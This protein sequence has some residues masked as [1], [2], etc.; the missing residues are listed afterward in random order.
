MGTA[1]A[2]YISEG[3]VLGAELVAVCDINKERLEWAR[4]HFEEGVQ[5]FEAVEDLLAFDGLDAVMICTLHYTHPDYAIKAFSH[6]LHVLIEKPAGVYT[7]QVREM[8]E[9]ARKSGLVFGIM[10]NQRTNPLYVKLREMVTSGELGEIRRTNWIITDWYR[11]QSYYDSGDWRA[12]WSGE[13]GGVLLNQ[14]PHQLDLWQWVIGMM[15]KRVRSFCS[16][17]KY[18]DIE[19]E[20][21]VTAYLEYE[22]GATGVF[23]TSIAEAP[24]TNRL[25]VIGDK[26]KVVVENDQINFWQLQ[27]SESEFNRVNTEKFARPKSREVP[28]TVPKEESGHHVIT[29]NWIEAMTKGTP[30][31]APGEEGINGLTL[32][33]AMYLSTWTEDWVQLPIDDDIYYEQLQKKIAQSTLA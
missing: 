13:G 33:N 19:V 9:A 21:E 31:I 2:Q 28:L 17:G 18:R 12:T 6:G 27:M 15:P 11:S 16:F 23:I 8:N 26:G 5:C 7:K 14:C 10:Y 3:K 24:G 25:E 32:S 22:N 29:Q 20:D 4:H 1:H 30:L